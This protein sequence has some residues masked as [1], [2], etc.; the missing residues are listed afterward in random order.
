MRLTKC[1]ICK[2]VINHAQGGAYAAVGTSALGGYEFC[3]KCGK[4][5][6]AFLRKHG[7]VEKT[8]AEATRKRRS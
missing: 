4:P 5:V 2:K 8:P 7:F 3:S 1:D 6:L